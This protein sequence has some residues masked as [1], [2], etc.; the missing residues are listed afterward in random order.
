MFPSLTTIRAEIFK[1]RAHRL[2]LVLTLLGA[3]AAAAPGVYFMFKAPDDAASYL[4]AGAGVFGLYAILAGAVFGGWVLGH[5]YRQETL[6]RVIP[7]DARRGRLL[8]AKALAGVIAFAVMLLAMF[9]VAV[10]SA[11]VAAAVNGDSLV[12]ANLGRDLGSL[13]LVAAVAAVV[14]FTTSAVFRSDTYATLTSLGALVVFAPLLGLVPAIGDFT[15]GSLATELAGWVAD[16]T[17]PKRGVAATSVALTAWV[18]ALAAV[19][20]SLFIRRDV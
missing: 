6:R 20:S 17:D 9:G 12:T 3:V 19:G 1:I 7:V 16:S 8:A 4:G 10:G 5:E 2:P 13:M 18:A 15:I 14:S 11:A